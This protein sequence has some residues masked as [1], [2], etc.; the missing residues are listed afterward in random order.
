MKIQGVTCGSDNLPVTNVEATGVQA[1]TIQASGA[2]S[3]QSLTVQG[4]NIAFQNADAFN[5]TSFTVDRNVGTTTVKSANIY[6]GPQA[7]EQIGNSQV[8]LNGN[9][10]ATSN[11]NASAVNATNVNGTLGVFTTAVYA[12]NL[13]VSQLGGGFAQF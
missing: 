13:F 7:S 8:Y 4:G 2:T 3:T 9:L 1:T 6:L 10:T 11:V 5:P 12:P